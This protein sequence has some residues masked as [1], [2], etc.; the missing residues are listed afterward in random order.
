MKRVL[1]KS[2]LRDFW[3]KHKDSEQYLKTWY[4]TAMDSDWNSPRDIKIAYSSAS[5]LLNDRV[6]F[7]IKG[8]HYRLMVRFNY[9][10]SWAFIRFI[11]THAEYDRIDAKT[12]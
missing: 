10:R 1:A 6:V 12:I 4:K 9:K 3:G 8:N 11:G 7:T 2:T 5:F